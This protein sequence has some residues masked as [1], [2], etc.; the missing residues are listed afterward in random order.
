MA[1]EPDVGTDGSL[2]EDEVSGVSSW[3]WVLYFLG[4]SALG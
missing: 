1:A 2:V 4:Q 3:G